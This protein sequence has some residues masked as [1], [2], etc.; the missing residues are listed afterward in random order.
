MEVDVVVNVERRNKQVLQ[1]LK[2]DLE[3][4]V[5]SRHFGTARLG[6][7]PL[8]LPLIRRLSTLRCLHSSLRL[9]AQLLLVPVCRSLRLPLGA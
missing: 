6:I 9:T 8:A 5:R 2:A 7:E 1:L 3:I 4:R